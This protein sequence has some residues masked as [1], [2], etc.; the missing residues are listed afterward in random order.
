MSTKNNI[1]TTIKNRHCKRAFLKKPIKKSILSKI[2]K[3]ATH[4]ASSK[5]SQPWQVC[6]L[7]KKSTKTL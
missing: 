6:V 1:L 7:S 4:A 2:L 5:N 3:A